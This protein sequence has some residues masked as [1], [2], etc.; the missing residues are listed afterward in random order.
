MCVYTLIKDRYMKV[1]FFFS[2][3]LELDL[4]DFIFDHLGGTYMT[5]ELLSFWPAHPIQCNFTDDMSTCEKLR[6]IG[7]R[8]WIFGHW[9]DENVVELERWAKINLT[10]QLT[11]HLCFLL[12]NS[13]DFRKFRNSKSACLQS[14]LQ[15]RFFWDFVYPAI[16]SGKCIS[17]LDKMLVIK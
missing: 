7:A 6:R 2:S 15:G 12:D 10:R 4:L 3:E 5:F 9:T 13:S 17:K 8:G 16:L 1:I 14:L 11:S